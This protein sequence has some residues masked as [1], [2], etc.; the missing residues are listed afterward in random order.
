MKNEIK[1][2]SYNK[3]NEKRK[4]G[5]YLKF[6]NQAKKSSIL[7]RGFLIQEDSIMYEKHEV[8]EPQRKSES[9]F[10]QQRQKE[11][12]SSFKQEVS[13]LVLLKKGSNKDVTKKMLNFTVSSFQPPKIK[14]PSIKYNNPDLDLNNHIKQMRIMDENSRKIKEEKENLNA[15]NNN[16]LYKKTNNLEIINTNEEDPSESLS[17]RLKIFSKFS[18]LVIGERMSESQKFELGIIPRKRNNNF[19]KKKD[20]DC[21][22]I[23]NKKNA[24]IN[25]CL[26]QKSNSLIK[27]T[28]KS[29]YKSDINDENYEYLNKKANKQ[30]NVKD[31]FFV[32]NTTKNK[33]S[34][35]FRKLINLNSTSDENKA[36]TDPKVKKERKNLAV[37]VKEQFNKIR[38]MNLMEPEKLKESTQDKFVRNKTEYVMEFQQLNREIGK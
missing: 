1:N 21:I 38:I 26:I 16:E 36:Q 8:E 29:K 31:E 3:P 12:K 30:S 2:S 4:T 33:N 17:K 7:K 32:V 28:A 23:T 27:F 18:D 6:L 19:N 10:N 37:M 14:K 25:N 9:N 35:Y 34:N 20:D 13:P 11:K 24:H 5:G 22:K 15:V